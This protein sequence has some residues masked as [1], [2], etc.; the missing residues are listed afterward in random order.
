VVPYGGEMN[1]RATT[2]EW[3]RFVSDG[4][5]ILL[6]LRTGECAHSKRTWAARRI[7]EVGPKVVLVGP[8][9]VLFFSLL[10]YFP[11]SLLSQFRLHFKFEFK[12][13]VKFVFRFHYTVMVLIL[14]IYF[15]I[16]ILCKFYT[17]YLFLSSLFFLF[18]SLGFKFEFM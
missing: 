9:S 16:Y 18:S 12:P 5:P 8:Y 14:K 11:F 1:A 17:L 4:G 13:C 15:Y 7:C 2:D 6:S 3:T 10:L